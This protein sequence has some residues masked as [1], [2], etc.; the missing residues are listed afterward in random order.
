MHGL[1]KDSTPLALCN[2]VVMHVAPQQAAL[3][4]GL[5]QLK[6][7]SISGPAG[8]PLLLHLPTSVTS[9]EADGMEELANGAEL[10]GVVALKQLCSLQLRG[11]KLAPQLLPHTTALTRLDCDQHLGMEAARAISRME[12]LHEC[13]VEPW[14]DM[15]QQLAG[16]QRLHRLGLY[17]RQEP[18]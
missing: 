5:T 3:L 6:E 14:E 4:S 7:L 18:E 11:C 9:L 15:A 2:T 8:A 12:G 17:Q 13:R 10:G 16:L 1:L